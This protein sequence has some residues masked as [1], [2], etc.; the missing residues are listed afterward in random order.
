MTA[1]QCR[2]MLERLSGWFSPIE[3][4]SMR[5]VTR[6]SDE[7]KSALQYTTDNETTQFSR[8]GPK[9]LNAEL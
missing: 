6:N 2:N 5:R 7:E 8:Y 9:Q 3:G 4:L 1:Q